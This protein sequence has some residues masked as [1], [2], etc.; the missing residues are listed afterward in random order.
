MPR[1]FSVFA[2]TLW[3]WTFDVQLLLAADSGGWPPSAGPFSRGSGGYFSVWKLVFCGLLFLL[4]VRTTDWISQD[5]QLNRLPYAIWNSATVFSFVAAF[6]LFWILPSFWIGFPLLLLAWGTPLVLYV[7]KR[8]A[9]VEMHERV[10]NKRHTRA[11]IARQVNKVGIK[12]EAETKSAAEQGPDLTLQAQGA[13]TERDDSVNLLTARQSPGFLTARELLYDGITHHAEG[14]MLDYSEAAVAVRYL[15]D[16]V[17]HN[18]APRERLTADPMLA[19]MKTL[20]A[21]NMNERRARQAG[22]FG[23]ETAGEKSTC[24][25]TTQGTQTGERVILQIEF[26]KPRFETLD[27]LGMRPKMQEQLH[28]LLQ[29]SGFFLFASLPGDGLTTMIDT[30]LKVTDKFTRHFVAVEEA[31]KRERDIE[32]VGVTTYDA[33]AGETPLSVLPKLVRTY[34]DAIVVRDLIN[35]ET[36]RFLCQQTKEQRVVLGSV[37]AKEAV[38]APLRVMLM[39]VPA[40]E[41]AP[42]ALG[43]L[44]LRLVRKLCEKCKEGYRPP[45]EVLKQFGLPPEKVEAF[46]RPPTAPIDPKNPEKVCEECQGVGYRG[47]TGIFELLVFDDALRQIL[48]ANPKLE[49]LRA[50]ARKAKNRSLQ[51]E[52][53]VLVAR[54]ATSLPELMRVLKK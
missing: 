17:W 45:A 35:A 38:E 53:L 31:S 10:F 23:M 12:M 28:D 7:K 48:A 14:V 51:D 47:R 30:V 33:A 34:P 25:I 5:C 8:N 39:K 49:A 3:V 44:N 42:T 36:V 1:C 41:F 43:V 18:Y 52:G 6:L 11:W 26:R 37:R 20:A 15:I 27:D 9:R 29:K 13:A 16:G 19:V 24:R 2:G 22:R 50:A 54:G 46:Y 21:L 40:E 4:W 32:N